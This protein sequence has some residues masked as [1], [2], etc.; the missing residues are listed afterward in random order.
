MND[1]HTKVL[2]YFDHLTSEPC[3]LLLVEHNSRA[4]KLWDGLKELRRLVDGVLCVLKFVVPG[5]TVTVEV[6]KQ[7]KLAR[8]QRA[9]RTHQVR[10]HATHEKSHLSRA[11]SS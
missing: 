4:K 3:A 9:I 6:R 5:K 8:A 10:K 7:T 11:F 2:N 1:E